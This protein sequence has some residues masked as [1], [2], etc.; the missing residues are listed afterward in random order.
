MPHRHLLDV[1]ATP[2]RQV[3]GMQHAA[4]FG[5]GTGEVAGGYSGRGMLYA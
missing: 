1:V 4:G 2:Q 3:L 5:H